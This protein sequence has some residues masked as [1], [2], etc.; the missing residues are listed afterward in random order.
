[1]ETKHT[2]PEKIYGHGF[3]AHACG[4]TAKHE[5][6]G[7]MFCKIHH[8]PTVQEKR[9]KRDE[10]LRQ[11]IDVEMNLRKAADEKRKEEKRRADCFPEL[12]QALEKSNR[13]LAELNFSAYIT[14]DSYA[15]VDMR[16]RIRA[17][18]EAAYSAIAKATGE[19][20]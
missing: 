18:H 7:V 6:K 12:L 4:K 2:C 17:G 16:Q 19:Q 14:G 1:M 5:H 3:G 20:P 11:K 9:K 8:P 10:E 13:L 15:E